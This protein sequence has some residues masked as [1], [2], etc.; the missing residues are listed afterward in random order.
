MVGHEIG[1]LLYKLFPFTPTTTEEEGSFE[2]AGKKSF[3]GREEG[4]GN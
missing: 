1:F 4:C 3:L 2:V